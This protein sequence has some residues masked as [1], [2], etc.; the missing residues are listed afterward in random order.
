MLSI[1]SLY[2]DCYLSSAMKSAPVRV[3]SVLTTT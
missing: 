1:N 2:Y 3:T